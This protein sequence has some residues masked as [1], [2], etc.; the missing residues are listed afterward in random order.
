MS[1]YGTTSCPD[2]S[3]RCHAS[4]VASPE[5]ARLGLDVASAAEQHELTPCWG[6]GVE[7]GGRGREVVIESFI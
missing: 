2:W 4:G 7:G 5:D 3:S 1:G 6:W